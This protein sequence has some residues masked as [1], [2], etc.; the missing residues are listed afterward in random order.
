VRTPLREV[1]ARRHR[2]AVVATVVALLLAACGGGSDDRPTLGAKESNDPATTTTV[3]AYTSFTAVPLGSEVA[4]HQQPDEASESEAYPNPWQLDDNPEHTVPQVLLVTEQ[5]DDWA[6]VLLPV[7]PNGTT[8]WVKKS[9]VRLTP[10]R[11]RIEVALGAHQIT[12]YDGDSVMIQEPIAVGKESTPTPTGKYYTRVLLKAPDPNTVYGPYAYGLS[13]HSEVL[14]EFNGGDA[15]L[16]IHGNN[17][18]SV[19]GQ[20]VSAG[21]I[22]MSNES[23]TRLAGI[24][25]LGTPVTISP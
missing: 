4:V 18:A 19:L 10:N 20:S 21:C 1:L 17:D 12:V 22:R 6:Q 23:I 9:D 11:F 7:R 15:E 13:G 24:L 3:P 5:Q 25:P 8:G 16:G 14:T 2:L